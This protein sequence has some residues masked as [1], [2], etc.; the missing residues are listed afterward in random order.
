MHQ[1]M[2]P[3]GTLG[4]MPILETAHFVMQHLADK[5]AS[6]HFIVG[7]RIKPTLYSQQVSAL[8]DPV[9]TI[10]SDPTF[11]RWFR[12]TSISESNAAV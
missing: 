7:S 1:L 12:S 11:Q 2:L 5:A 8:S 4:L 3:D 9:C 10:L 6:E